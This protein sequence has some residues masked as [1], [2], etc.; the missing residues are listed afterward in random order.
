VIATI[1]AVLTQVRIYDVE[2][3]RIFIE[4]QGFCNVVDSSP[5]DLKNKSSGPESDESVFNTQNEVWSIV[6]RY[7][8]DN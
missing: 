3:D 6:I 8:F 2:D 5:S 4:N 7:S 1:P